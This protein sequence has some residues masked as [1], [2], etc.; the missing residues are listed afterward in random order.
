M[1]ITTTETSLKTMFWTASEDGKMVPHGAVTIPLPSK[2]IPQL[3]TSH[4]HATPP[5]HPRSLQA[6]T[7]SSSS[8][9]SS[10]S[11]SPGIYSRSTPLSPSAFGSVLAQIQAQGQGK[12]LNLSPVL[13]T[14]PHPS[15]R[16]LKPQSPHP[17]VNM[18]PA[19][20]NAAS[21][22]PPRGPR[23]L[24][25]YGV[26]PSRLLFAGPDASPG[27]P[28]SQFIPRGPSADRDRDRDRERVDW[29]LRDRKRERWLAA[30]ARGRES[31]GSE[32]GR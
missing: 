19:S 12:A 3:N 21:S 7:S 17:Q 15:Q 24:M 20:T 6:A 23:T 4:A 28:V 8:S 13:Q 2:P 22:P 30:R 25:N 27:P 32:W 11:A 18:R 16:E 10:S 1:S 14:P 5:T 9:S 29:D 26:P 31:G